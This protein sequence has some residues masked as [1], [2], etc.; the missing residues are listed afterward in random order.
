VQSHSWKASWNRDRVRA[1]PRIILW[2]SAWLLL[3]IIRP[4]SLEA[5]GGPP[6]YTN[7]P[8]TPG[9]LRWEINVSY[10]PFLSPDQSMTHTPDLDLNFGLGD[11]IQLTCEVA[12]L[13]L[14]L[15]QAPPKHGLSQDMLGVK[16]RFYD[17]AERG[18][19]I[20]VFPQ[21]SI[22][23]PTRSVKR[24]LVP[25]GGSLT[26]PVE[27][28]KRLGPIAVNGEFGYSLVHLGPNEWL[29][30]IV[31][32]HEKTIGHKKTRT[33]E[34]DA[35]FYAAGKVDGPVSQETV[36]AGVRYKIH[37]PVILLLMAGRGLHRT[38]Q[39]QPSFV[40]YLGL[41]VLLPRRPFERNE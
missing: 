10:M 16:W 38:L 5:Q 37:P 31:A 14:D 23:N 9:H 17:I 34:F 7:D 26:L 18:F 12:W 6:Y 8:W 41:Q 3:W 19:A 22:N 35:E 30:G 40:G 36:G 15:A 13:R 32:G 39:S 20:S 27:L 28:S 1:R 21:A 29:A 25:P 33:V 4:C 11:R 24:G 2:S